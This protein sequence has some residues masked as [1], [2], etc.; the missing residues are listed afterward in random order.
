MWSAEGFDVFSIDGIRPVVDVNT[1]V[2]NTHTGDVDT[3]THYVY[4]YEGDTNTL[5]GYAPVM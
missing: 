5:A 1:G 3:K 4:V 2:G